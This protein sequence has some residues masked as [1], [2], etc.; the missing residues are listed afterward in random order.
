M[1]AP[2]SPLAPD[3]AT[4][5]S[6]RSSLGCV[7]PFGLL[8]AAIG[9]IVFWFSTVRPLQRA[10]ASDRWVE[11][12]CEVV[13]SEL[14]ESHGD[15]STTYRVV[16]RYRYTWQ[17]RRLESDR[18][19]FAQGSTNIGVDRMRAAVS[20]HP[21]G[22]RTVCFVNPADPT[23]AVLERRP[24]RSV[25]FGAFALLFPA[26]GITI[27][28]LTL[29]AA[30]Q[31]RA[32]ARSPLAVTT[33]PSGIAADDDVAPPAG[34][35]LL[36]PVAGRTAAFVGIGFFALFWNGIVFVG[37]RSVFSGGIDGIEWFVVLFLVPFV[38]IGLG[39]LALT[40]HACSRLFAPGLT[41]RTDP[42][43]LRLGARV[44]VRWTLNRSGVK[45]LSIRLV[46]REEATYR[47]GTSTMTDRSELYRADVFESTDALSLAEG[48]A[49]LALPAGGIVPA[50]IGKNNKIVWEL[51]FDGS[52]PWGADLDDRFAL[53][54]R[55]PLRPLAVAAVPAP[56]AWSGGGVTLW[57]VDSYAP[58]ERLFFTL[59]RDG[60]A[61]PG[62]LTV[63]LG[64]FTEGKG[65]RDAALAWSERIE[66]LAPGGQRDFEV[67]L[68]AAPWS[69][70]GKLIALAWRLE[71]LDDRG[72]PLV[73]IPLVIG[74]G[75]AAT[76]LTALPADPRRKGLARWFGAG[77]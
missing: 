9:L 13:A 21:P 30:R 25:W 39:M 1:D 10:A 55:G 11:T 33:L 32:A 24:P 72:Q 53:P 69:F 62:P 41:V 17:G 74:P 19:D 37:L 66:N 4:E 65:T 35:T 44:P 77:S 3:P 76:T 49:E 63:Q 27:V 38:L 26:F 6:L 46:A 23:S 29:R 60:A 68:P 51:V 71:V 20:A 40:L 16:V 59:A 18:Y 64:W 47:Q 12:P 45:K 8:F 75:G 22:R 34:E 57:A 31:A 14:V 58:G 50:F 43:L 15:D 67:P 7:V 56:R 48:R 61:T 73:G 42:S 52:I 2:A 36:K 5:R 70:S 28:A 54:V